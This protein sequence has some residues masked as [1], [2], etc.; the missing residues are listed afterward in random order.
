VKT[1]LE[2][3]FPEELE[4]YFRLRAT[5]D[6]KQYGTL[7]NDDIEWLDQANNRFGSPRTEE[8]YAIWCCSERRKDEWRA[9]LRES[10]P[11]TPGGFLHLFS[12]AGTPSQRI[13]ESSVKRTSPDDFTPT[14]RFISPPE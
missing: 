8:L 3:G 2:G 9:L 5:W 11:P 13:K 1:P 6:G 14:S 10:Q 4:R 12:D 7:S